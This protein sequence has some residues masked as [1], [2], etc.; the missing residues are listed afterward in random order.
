MKLKHLASAAVIAVSAMLMASNS[1]SASTAD[2]AGE[3]KT[4]TQEKVKLP[5]VFFPHLGHTFDPVVDG[6]EVT[7]DFI[8]QNKG[9]A[10]LHII[11][12]QTG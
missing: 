12:V 10:P 5:A 2:P 7:H 3:E 9:D 4:M 11:K 8:V 6:T 1:F